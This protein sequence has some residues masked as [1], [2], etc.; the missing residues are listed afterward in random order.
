MKY[1]TAFREE[2]LQLVAQLGRQGLGVGQHQRRS[3]C[4]GDDVGHRERL[5]R[6]CGPQQG[7]IA[8]TLFTPATNCLIA[9]GWSPWGLYA[10]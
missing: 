8:L 4:L 2:L 1:S 10:P 3:A 7:L 6:A 9:V 5:A